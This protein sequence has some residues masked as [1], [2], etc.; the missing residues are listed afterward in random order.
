MRQS[1]QKA[2]T[3]RTGDAA[4]GH[5]QPDIVTLEQDRQGDMQFVARWNER[6][7]RDVLIGVGPKVLSGVGPR[8]MSNVSKAE[9]LSSMFQVDVID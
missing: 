5:L 3:E 1:L 2:R 9:E 7:V 4:R 8:A 6:H